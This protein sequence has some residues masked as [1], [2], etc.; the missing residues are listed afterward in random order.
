[1]AAGRICGYPPARAHLAQLVEHF[2]GK[3]GVAGSSPAEGS[4]RLVLGHEI[5]A[6]LGGAETYLLTVAEHLERLGH[7]VTVRTRQPG[8]ATTVARDRGLR[9]RSLKLS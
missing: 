2:H 4:I 3:E 7:E 6:S 1:M 8:E 5:F 9:Q